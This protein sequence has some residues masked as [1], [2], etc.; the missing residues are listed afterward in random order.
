MLGCPSEG[1]CSRSWS[2]RG[3]RASQNG[4]S[5]RT[6]RTHFRRSERFPQTKI[7]LPRR[8]SPVR[9]RPGALE[10]WAGQR[11]ERC[12]WC[13]PCECFEAAAISEWS[14]PGRRRGHLCAGDNAV[15]FRT[16]CGS[17]AAAGGRGGI[18]A[19]GGRTGALVP[20]LAER[21]VEFGVDLL[22]RPVQGVQGQVV[23]VGCLFEC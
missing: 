4:V 12:R 16:G 10:V 3:Q 17:G 14:V 18:G 9:I 13:R 8:V 5:T 2:A 21:G 6:T 15:T 23:E 1:P 20:L 19:R 11:G 7:E 22:V